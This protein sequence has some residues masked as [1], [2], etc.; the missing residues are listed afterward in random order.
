MVE[1]TRLEAG[2]EGLVAHV[3][4]FAVRHFLRIVDQ[5]V[6]A[7]EMIDHGF[8]AGLQRLQAL[9]LALHGERLAATALD[10][11]DGVLQFRQRAAG[12]RHAGAFGGEREGDALAH[13]LA[14]AGD[15]CDPVV[16]QTH[17]VSPGVGDA[18]GA[19]DMRREIPTHRRTALSIVS[20]G[21]RR[22]CPSS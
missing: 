22:G 12:N 6:E 11:G 16:E 21:T 1:R 2:L 20:A 8:H 14:G 3:E 5:D 19:G 15:E 10:L 9:H 17:D 18:K 4:Q 7:T 13:A